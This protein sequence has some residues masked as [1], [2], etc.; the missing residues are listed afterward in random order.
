M[1]KA[2][3]LSYPLNVQRRLYSDRADA[4]SNLSLRL[5]RTHFEGFIMSLPNTQRHSLKMHAQTNQ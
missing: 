3:V 2:L 4:K 1:K 5:A